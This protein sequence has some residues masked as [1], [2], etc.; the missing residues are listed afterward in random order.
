MPLQLINTQGLT[1]LP[2]PAQSYSEAARRIESLQAK[3]TSDV[4]PL[5]RADFMT[6]GRQ[7]ER[8]ILFLHGYTNCARQ[9]HD[10]GRLFYER[11]YNVFNARLP[12]H[13]LKDRLTPRL[14][15]LTAVELVALANEVT[16][17]GRGLGRHVTL[18]GISAGGVAAAWMA[19]NRTDVDQAVVI[20]PSFAFTLV[21]A[22][23]T[24]P[25]TALALALPNLFLWWDSDLKTNIQP[26]YGYPRFATRSLAEIVRLGYAVRYAARASKPRGGK[27]ILVT[28]GNDPAVDNQVAY[29]VADGWQ[30]RHA[31]LVRYEFDP[32]LKLLHDL[33]DPNQIGQRVDLV[34]PKLIELIDS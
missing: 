25:L 30:K 33:I 16:D 20:A 15:D 10:L 24:K 8:A 1:P 2:R 17:I 9:F 26:D 11:G 13:G 5:C 4:N 27:M 6:H 28:V 29:A 14:A 22:S 7:T 19:Q 31:N 23:L 21:P 34:Y 32:A 18:G 3:D 12:W